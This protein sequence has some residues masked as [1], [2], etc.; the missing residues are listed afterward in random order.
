MS[1]TVSSLRFR[2]ALRSPDL[3]RPDWTKQELREPGKLW[4]DKNENS[5]PHLQAVLSR[6]MAELPPRAFYS[7]PD[8]AGLYCKLADWVGV[9]PA[10]LL[11]AA[12]SDGV[13]RSCFEALVSEGDR[14]VHTVPTFA[15]YPVYCRI[16]GCEAVPVAYERRNNRPTLSAVRVIDTIVSSRPTLVCLPNPDSP[17]GTVFH[18][19]ELERIIEAA[20]S[21]GAAI[22]VDEAYHPFHPDSVVPWIARHPHLIVARSTGKAWGM[23][24]F[25]AGY[26]V[27]APEV[28]AMLHKVR[29]MYEIS[30]VA[31]HVFEAMLSHVDEMTASV[32][33]LQ[34]GKSTFV[35]R[36][37]DLGFDA[38]DTAGSF[39]HV[40]F[41]SSAP[42]VHAALSDLAYYRRDGG[43]G[44]LSGFS[45]FSATTPELFQPLIDRVSACLR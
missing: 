19:D 10:N 18:P 35:A 5:D 36:M 22:L 40:D 3:V 23:A 26:A 29:P 8:S 27:A 38:F 37:R 2:S 20:G 44:C 45:R 1:Q 6:V 34:D 30:T 4:L 42:Q 25:R 9:S 15:M 14:V 41:G 7:Y 28:T 16:R 39:L 21:V 33:R 24:G 17:T 43:A 31:V 13:I 11:L 32:R 12:G